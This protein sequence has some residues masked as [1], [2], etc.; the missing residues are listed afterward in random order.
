MSGSCKKAG[1]RC[2][3]YCERS[4]NCVKLRSLGSPLALCRACAVYLTPGALA[5]TDS[6]IG[7]RRPPCDGRDWEVQCGRCGSSM[8][9]ELVCLSSPEW[10]AANPLLARGTVPRSTP[11]WFVMTPAVEEQ[12]REIEAVAAEWSCVDGDG[13]D[14]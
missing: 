14:G 1:I 6:V 5:M 2:R 9:S 13:L 7:P 10:C 8:D 4:L 3:C 12:L 11:E